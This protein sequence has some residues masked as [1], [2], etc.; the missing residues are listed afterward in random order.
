MKED[1]RVLVVQDEIV[2]MN[3]GDEIYWFWHTFA[4]I[5][6]SDPR[7]VEIA[8]A[9]AT[10]TAPDGKRLQLQFDANV[11]F[12]LRR[13]MSVPLESS[14]APFD[15]LQGGI[16]SNLLTVYFKTGSQPVILRVSAWEDGR[17]YVPGEL[18]A[19]ER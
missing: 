12:V 7:A 2:P 18:K 10:L 9:M 15:Q 11:P 16:I 17:D 1:R 13:G 8:D 6:F 14:P 19:F 5:G 3:A 4:R